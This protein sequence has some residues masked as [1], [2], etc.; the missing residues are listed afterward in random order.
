[1]LLL[2]SPNVQSES[3]LQA[4]SSLLSA[5]LCLY[6]VCPSPPPVSVAVVPSS[7]SQQS[8]ALVRDV[9]LIVAPPH[10]LTLV[11]AAPSLP[12][13]SYSHSYTPIVPLPV[14]ASPSR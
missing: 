10:W 8:T 1:M 9:L 14:L 4:L 13:L 5:L 2:P 3:L 11:A 7:R 6:G 12:L